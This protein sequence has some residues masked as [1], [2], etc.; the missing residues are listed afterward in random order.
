LKKNLKLFLK[1]KYKQTI[2][3]KLTIKS[4]RKGPVIK[5]A[6]IKEKI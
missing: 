1:K 5:A 2:A 6:G 3:P 4:G